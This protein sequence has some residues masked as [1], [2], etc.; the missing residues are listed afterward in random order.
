MGKKL[1]TALKIGY[2]QQTSGKEWEVLHLTLPSQK[3][4]YSQKEDEEPTLVHQLPPPSAKLRNSDSSSDSSFGSISSGRSKKKSHSRRTLD[5]FSTKLITV[6]N[7]AETDQQRNDS[8][9]ESLDENQTE[10]KNH[11]NTLDVKMDDLSVQNIASQNE[12]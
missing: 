3:M 10:V 4:R 1:T 11:L 5:R 6:E 2:L 9:F 7:K 8:R 12:L